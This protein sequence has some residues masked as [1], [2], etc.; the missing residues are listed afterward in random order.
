MRTLL[1]LPVIMVLATA[2]D[3][4][5]AGSAETNRLDP[6]RAN[7]ASAPAPAEPTTQPAD[8]AKVQ[9]VPDRSLGI[10]AYVQAG[11]PAP[12]RQWSGKDYQ[13]AAAILRQIS[14]PNFSRLPRVDSPASGQLFSRSV[15]PGNLDIIPGS[16]AINTAANIAVFASYA[17]VGASQPSLW[18]LDTTNGQ[19]LWSLTLGHISGSPTT[20]LDGAAVYVASDAGVLYKVNTTTG[21]VVWSFPF[22]GEPYGAPWVHYTGS[23]LFLADEDGKVWSILDQGSSAAINPA[24]GSGSG[25]A[26]VQSPSQVVLSDIA[27]KMYVGASDGKIWELSETTGAGSY[28]LIASAVGDPVVHRQASRL[29]FGSASGRIHCLTIPFVRCDELRIFGLEMGT[30]LL[31]P[32]GPFGAYDFYGL[33]ARAT[34]RG[35]GPG[36]HVQ[37]TRWWTPSGHLYQQFTTAFSAPDV[38]PM[39][40]RP[41]GMFVPRSDSGVSR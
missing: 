41:I 13:V 17:G 36:A 9:L 15:A 40:P 10:E 25:Y 35:L 27:G 4:E 30:G 22:G 7:P 19:M 14:T 37:T 31:Y 29:M 16:P 34:W 1:L 12:D 23:M 11:I 28:I 33:R 32:D 5:Q 39:V 18:A 24:W 3:R 6:G 26:Q 2:C 21:Q 38:S 8:D 20:S